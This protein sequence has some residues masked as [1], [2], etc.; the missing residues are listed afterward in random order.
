MKQLSSAKIG[1]CYTQTLKKDIFAIICHL[2]CF[3]NLL[4]TNTNMFSTASLVIDIPGRAGTSLDLLD[5]C[6]P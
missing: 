2:V 5:W 6:F 4:S 1:I 3:K